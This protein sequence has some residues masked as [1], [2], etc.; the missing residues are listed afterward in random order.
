MVVS[1]EVLLVEVEVLVLVT[2]VLLMV[3]SSEKSIIPNS[4]YSKQ[5]YPANNTK[6]LI[7]AAAEGTA[8]SILLSFPTVKAVKLE[9][10]KPNRSPAKAG[11]IWR[12]GAT[13]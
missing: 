1:V 11:S 8:E 9:I 10:K 3:S 2:I 13:Q 5:A 6:K 4:L 12:G 7:E